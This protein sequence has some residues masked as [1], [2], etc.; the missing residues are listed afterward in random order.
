MDQGLRA[1]QLPFTPKRFNLAFSTE[2]LDLGV[3]NQTAGVT[4]VLVYLGSSLDPYLGV[5]Q[6]SRA[7][8]T[9]VLVFGAMYQGAILVH[10]FEPQTF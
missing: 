6:N 9:Q 3:A 8:I 1:S 4:H 10:L 5:V 2:P 7:R